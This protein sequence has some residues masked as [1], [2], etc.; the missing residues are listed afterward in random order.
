MFRRVELPGGVSGKLLLHSMPGRCEPLESVW[1]HARQEKVGTI[2][3]LAGTR[4][5]RKKSPEY[6]IA[7]EAGAVPFS[8]RTLEI[9][10]YCVPDDRDAF[11]ALVGDIAAQLRA[12]EAVLVHC[13]AGVG[14][15]GTFAVC[16]LHALG[17]SAA[18]ALGAVSRAE[19]GPE[20]D[21]QQELISWHGSRRSITA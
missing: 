21:G 8:V 2:V 1:V 6:A 14:R 12:G 7:L 18:G 15:T 4:E 20:T 9:P 3:C 5:L 13:G 16:V 19:S 11:A 10:D 17:V